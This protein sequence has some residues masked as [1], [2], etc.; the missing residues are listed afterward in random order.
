MSSQDIFKEGNYFKGRIS[1]VEPTLEAAFVDYGADRHGFLPLK[2]IEGYDKRLH[3]EGAV[4]TVCISKAEYKQKGAA[5][6][7]LETISTGVTVHNFLDQNSSSGNIFKT[8]LFCSV[9]IGVLATLV[10]VN[11]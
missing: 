5:L 11:T 7:A 9:I 8:I 10:Y 2:E 4:L 3:K 6:S 1:R